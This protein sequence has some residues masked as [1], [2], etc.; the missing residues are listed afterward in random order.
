MELRGIGIIEI[1]IGIELPWGFGTG[2]GNGVELP[3]SELE[4]NGKSGIDPSSDLSSQCDNNDV[5][6]SL[7]ASVLL[8]RPIR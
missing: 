1:G 6:P 4:L 7:Q 2:I 8:G 3:L 5:Q